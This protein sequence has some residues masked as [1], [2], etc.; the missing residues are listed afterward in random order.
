MK[1]IFLEDIPGTADAGEVKN[2]KNGFA[3]NYLL[4]RELAVPATHDQLQRLGTIQRAAEK[5]RLQTS[6]EMATVAEALEGTIVTIEARLGPTGRLYGAVTSRHVAEA[7]T[8]QTEREL[9]HRHVLLPE[10]IHAP[11]N[12]PVTVRLYRD[13]TAQVTVSVVAE[14]YVPEDAPVAEMEEIIAEAEA[15]VETE[16]PDL[17]EEAG[18]AGEPPGT[19]A[20]TA[21]AEELSTQPEA[22]AEAEAP[23]LGEEA[24][25]AEKPPETEAPTAQAEELS[26]EP[27]APAEAEAPDLGEEAGEAKEPSD[28][29]QPSSKSA[30]E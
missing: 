19:E 15:P 13:V 24:G 7:L 25:E 10:A 26:T 22:P 17:G 6:K 9:D 18:E 5:K 30:Q 29:E 11:G 2:V 21:Q 23:D 8:K 28:D 20:P 12:Y 4:P 1:V 14:G 16:A 27:E 3:R